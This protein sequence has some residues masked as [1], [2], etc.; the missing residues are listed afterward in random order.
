MCQILHSTYSKKYIIF[1]LK[2]K[3]YGESYILSGIP[4]IEIFLLKIRAPTPDIH[5]RY[6]FRNAILSSGPLKKITGLLVRKSMHAYI[7]LILS[8]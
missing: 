5:F 7:V 6:S 4:I 3:L 1:Y 2:F 8:S